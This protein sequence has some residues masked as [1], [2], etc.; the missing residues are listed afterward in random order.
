MLSTRAGGVGINLTAAD[1]CIIFDSDWNPQNDV[2][3]QARCHRIGQTKPV[4]IYR[5]ITS[6]SFETEMF[7]RASKKLGLE[8]AVLGTFDQNEEDGK[9]TAQE[10]EQ[11]LKKGA[12]ALLEDDNDEIT[13]SFCA[14]DIESILAKRTRTRVVEG[15]KTATWLNKQGMVTKSKFSS[16]SKSAALDMDDPNFWEKVMPDFVTPSIMVGK[17]AELESHATGAG[18]KKKGGRGRKKKGSVEEEAA[19]EEEENNKAIKE[20]EAK[21]EAND[22]GDVNADEDNAEDDAEE[23]TGKDGEFHI[24]RTNQKRIN[25]FI[26]DLKSMMDGIFEE[27]EDDKM[28]DDEKTVCE[29]LLLT[30]SCKEKLFSENQRN[31]AKGMLKRLEG[32][33]RRRCRDPNSRFASISNEPGTPE[34]NEKLMIR[35]TKKRRKRR[36]PRNGDDDAPATET[37]RGRKAPSDR[38]DGYLEHSDS[39]GEWSGVEDN[40]YDKSKKKDGISQKEAR[41][42]RA[43]ATGKDAA[44]AAGQMWPSLP[45]D[46]V[47]SVLGSLLDKVIK[48]DEDKSGGLFSQPVPK[49]EFPEY[50][51]VVKKPMDYSTMKRKCARREYRSAQAM[52]KDF[53]LIMSNCVQFN[54]PDSDIVKEA[55]K[56]VLLRPSLLREAAMENRLFLAEDGAV[57]DIYSDDEGDGPVNDADGNP[58][59]QRR[60]RKPGPV[61]KEVKETKKLVRCQKCSPCTRD[62]CGECEACKDKKKFGGTGTM[63]QSCIH[64]NCESLKEMVVKAKRG[65]P[66]KQ[67]KEVETQSDVA[68][69][70][71]LKETGEDIPLT[72]NNWKGKA[73]SNN[74]LEIDRIPKKRKNEDS[75]PTQN[76][77]DLSDGETDDADLSDGEIEEPVAKKSRRNDDE[78]ESHVDIQAL[79]KDRSGLDGSYKS[80][81]ANYT[82]R[83]PWSLPQVLKDHFEEVAK[84]TITIIKKLDAYDLFQKAVTEDDAP[85]YFD[86]VK[87]PMDFGTMAKKLE[88]GSYGNNGIDQ[89]YE[90][91]LL[92]L[93]N[94]ALYNEDNEEI[95]DE[96]ATLLGVLPVTYAKACVA[97]QQKSVN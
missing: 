68:D 73:N 80:A 96:A 87:K 1:V 24:T 21:N 51:E 57:I 36:V 30:I 48:N 94:C 61:K 34:V 83:G 92:V 19:K 31:L 62:D 26:Q 66:P 18:P 7:D 17:L 59:K 91:F 20:E 13:K 58:V 95:L 5:L 39:E 67:K 12:Y 97:I 23:A 55:R 79:E 3:A 52:Q 4:R 16:D 56:Q 42:R 47:A 44:A 6:R 11:L 14:D 8:Q 86:V 88:S 50:Y 54:A 85:G 27:L 45:R 60:G 15:T 32:D 74:G 46:K 78:E 22:N 93:D 38:D 90:D 76:D 75:E 69:D 72:L 28:Q 43:W 41:R 63:K 89:V 64:R 2:Q 25:K 49:D 53:V 65:R 37:K 84:A 10:M 33:R 40:V 9:P 70:T 77:A 81:R 71:G 35:S 29:N 82:K